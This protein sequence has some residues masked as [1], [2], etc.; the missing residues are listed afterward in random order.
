VL[1]PEEIAMDLAFLMFLTILVILLA[2]IGWMTARLVRVWL[3]YRGDRVLTCPETKQTVG[4]ALDMKHAVWSSFGHAPSLRL[5]TCS[6]W[7]ERQDCGQECLREIEESPD[8]CL[9]RTIL[10]RW[11]AGKDCAIC[12]KA[13]GEI[14]WS[15]HRPALLSPE[16]RTVEWA[17]V[18]AESIPGVLETHAP[19]CWNCHIVQTFCREHPDMVVDRA[20]SARL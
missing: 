9:V 14:H 20:R 17:Q 7:P 10:T 15:D 12:G 2:L 11:Y 1:L 6:R 19:V 8:D 5:E 4:V 18:P 3:N 13:I 16:R